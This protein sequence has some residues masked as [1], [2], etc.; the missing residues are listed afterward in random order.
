MTG[1]IYEIPE[2]LEELFDAREASYRIIDYGK[3]KEMDNGQALSYFLELLG[4]PE[5]NIHERF[6]TQV[7]LCSGNYS[8][9]LVID[10]GG[11]GD[12]FSHGFTVTF[13]D[14][15]NDNEGM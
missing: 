12:F 4:I 1:T 6:D 8:Y 10:S 5:A 14:S 7:Y 13:D 2:S 11:L 15:Y 9:R 3:N